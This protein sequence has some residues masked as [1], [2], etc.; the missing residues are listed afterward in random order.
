MSTLVNEKTENIWMR[1]AFILL[2]GF[3]YSVAE[4]VM[5]A[6]VALQFVFILFTQNKNPKVLAFGA[7]LSEYLYQIFRY[8]TFNTDNRPFP[9]TEWPKGKTE[10]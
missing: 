1:G 9:F 3:I 10:D 4:V 2:F 6:V 7:D 8:L 5:I